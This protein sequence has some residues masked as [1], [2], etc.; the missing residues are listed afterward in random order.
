MGEV[1]SVRR[2]S[3]DTQREQQDSFLLNKSK[4]KTFPVLQVEEAWREEEKFFSRL[5]DI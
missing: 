5:P 1:T 4:K 2:I 3:Y